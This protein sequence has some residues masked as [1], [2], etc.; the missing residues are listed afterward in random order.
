[1]N[2]IW[3]IHVCSLALA[4]LMLSGPAAAQEAEVDPNQPPLIKLTLHPS[5][6]GK[7]A[8]KYH[9][10]PDR[11]D[12]TP[13]NAAQ[14]YYR[15]LL[16]F[17]QNPGRQAYHKEEAEHSQRWA[18]EPCEGEV[19]EQIKK[20]LAQFPVG[21]KQQLREAVYR[22]HCNFDYRLQDR[23]GNEIFQFL[24]P[25]IQ[26]MRNF[27]RNLRMQARVEISERR[28]DDAAES[29]RQGFQMGKDAASEPLL[30]NGLVGIAIAGLMNA[31]VEHWI[32]S[33]DSPNLYWAVG[34]IPKPLVDLRPA[35]EQ[36]VRFPE[37]MFPF[38]KDAETSQ[39][40]PEEWQR[41]L[42]AAVRQIGNMELPTSQQEQ[43]TLAKIQ[44]DLAVMALIMRA[45][46][47]AKE[48]MKKSGMDADKLNKMP[49]AQVVAIH[50][51]R[52]VRQIG[53]EFVKG[54]YL[55]T[56]QR[57]EYYAALEKRL[58]EEKLLGPGSR[59]MIPLSSLLMPAVGQALM[60][61]T[62]LERDFA[63]LQTLEAIRAHLAETGKLPEK[64]SDITVVPVPLNPSTNEP[65]EYRLADGVATLEVPPV[66]KGLSPQL[67][68]RYELSA[69]KQ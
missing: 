60:A 36:E 41:V 37:M 24:L 7:P 46:P 63:A 61:Q 54:G 49:V 62:R 15:A 23:T 17:T 39:R 35:L 34:A 25:E 8:L 65:F 32:G 18:E 2:S 43:N 57:E 20:W 64:L 30:I 9:L 29:L 58:Q 1:M 42:S 45:Y 12:R 69:A 66:R 53:D 10:L 31:E 68:K 27:S 21:A 38:L 14:F 11:L 52:T 19:R 16:M 47:V 13:G 59:E 5:S 40:S 51:Q 3:R 33:P 4:L 44:S 28:Y 67:G 26:E 56:K 50:V 22:E 6:P 55:P 48:E